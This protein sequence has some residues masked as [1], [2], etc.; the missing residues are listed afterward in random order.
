[1]GMFI[2]DE[3]GELIRDSGGRPFRQWRDHIK[4]PDDIWGEIVKAGQIPGTT[5]APKLQPIAT[6]IIMLQSGMRA[7]MGVKVKGPDLDTIEQ[8]G[9]EIERLLKDVP[10]VEPTAVIA[11][12]I[13][14]KPYIEIDI[15]RDAIARYGIHIRKMQ[16]VIEVAIGGRRVTT[17]VE[18]RERYGVRVRY[19]RELRDQIE[20]LGKIL[21]PA[22][23]GPQIPLIQLADIRY[24][25]GPQ[26]IKSEDTFLI[27]YVLFD[28]KSGYAEVDVVEDCQ[29]YLKAK[30]ESGEFVVPAGVSYTF[31][32]S[33]ENQIRAARTLS[34]VIPV[35]LFIIFMILYFQFKST[36]VSLLVFS[37]IIVAWSGGFLMIWLY[38]RDWFL[39]FDVFGTNMR[40]LFGV[41]TINLSVAIWVGFL[42][43]FGIASDDGVVMCTYLKQAFAEKGSGAFSE[44]KPTSPA[45]IHRIVIA[46]GMRRIRPCLMTT[47]TTILA[48]IPVLT[49]TGRGADIM[50]PMAIPSFGGMT[51]EV[52]TMLVVPVLYSMTKEFRARSGPQ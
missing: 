27:G 47:A 7:P 37:G 14:G 52:L 29:Q 31:A 35:A 21:V 48:L 28:K 13:V 18:G 44:K 10:S 2:R 24:V 12:R 40:E 30:I 26:A 46:A 36:V 25:R 17:T 8:V 3:D 16:D 22:P 50:V 19:V 45:E 38:G 42:A 5:S 23:N 32:G 51:I 15:D 6:R 39:N 20:S 9:L 43:L 41:H 4:N 34:V 49:S 11:D 1:M 33:Y